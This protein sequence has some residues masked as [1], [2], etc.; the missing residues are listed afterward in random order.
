MDVRDNVTLE[1]DVTV[2]GSITV[3]GAEKIDLNGKTITL[4]DKD[5]SVTA[6]ADLGES[7]FVSFS[8]DYVVKTTETDGKFVYSLVEKVWPV[9]V[10][11]NGE[12]LYKGDDLTAAFAAAKDGSTITVHENLTLNDNVTVTGSI[13]VT[14]AD[15]IDLNGKTITLADKD[16][17]VTA[18]ADLGE[19]SFVSF[20]EDYE[21]K[22]TETDGKFV[23][24][25]VEK[26]WPVIVTLNGEVLYKGNDLTAAF[27]AAK[28]GSTITINE[29]LTLDS[30]VVV[31]DNITIVNTANLGQNGKQILLS[32]GGSITTD[33][34]LDVTTVELYMEVVRQ[35]STYVLKALT[36]ELTGAA[37][38][39]N[40]SVAGGKVD[41]DYIILDVDPN[42]IN[43]SI[44]KASLRFFADNAE[45]VKVTSVTGLVSGR[46][47]NGAKVTVE[48]GNSASDQK[49]TKTYTIIILGDVNG[50][51]RTDSG[52]ST[53]MDSSY[54]G[55]TTLS[56][57]QKLAADMNRNG[58]IESG[59]SA[60][61]A[62]KYTY[63]WAKG[64]YKSALQ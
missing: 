11:L 23:Y 9:I 2:T 64:L 41:G 63:M 18:D 55:R 13:T 27:A 52:D 62:T 39:K 44:L 56:D 22:T 60:K 24:S 16:S 12:V 61:N 19:S 54:L 43:E 21:V 1:R 14:G 50:N 25:L 35:G 17:S 32:K 38:T 45:W 59:D 28:D 31:K 36:P 46:V 5:S 3:T 20:S 7:S 49:A 10:T 58:R 29:S 6:D 33:G 30:N 53:L 34:E 8:E 26:V 48:A 37:V 42:G 57:I 15:K 47:A 4:A 51:G 40:D